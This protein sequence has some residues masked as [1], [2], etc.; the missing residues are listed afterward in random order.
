[1]MISKHKFTVMTKKKTKSETKSSVEVLE[2]PPVGPTQAE[3]DLQ[4]LKAKLKKKYHLLTD[5]DLKYDDKE[6]LLSHVCLVLGLP[7]PKLDWVLIDL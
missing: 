5:E 4:L 2:S 3:K 6:T 1:V 7:R